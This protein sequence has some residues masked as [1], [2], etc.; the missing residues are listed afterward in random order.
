[1]IFFVTSAAN[2][3]SDIHTIN[4]IQKISTNSKSMFIFPL[5][6][7]DIE[8]ILNRLKSNFSAGPDDL[9]PVIIKESKTH[10]TDI[11]TYAK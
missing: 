2:L 9:A 7:K 10:L 3:A 6:T 8:N 4:V 11:P 5:S 1:M